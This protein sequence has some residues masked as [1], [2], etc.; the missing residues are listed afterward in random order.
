ME[1]RRR[2]GNG[3]REKSLARSSALEGLVFISENFGE[4]GGSK[5]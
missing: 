3:R 1:A 4:T 5:Y 2:A